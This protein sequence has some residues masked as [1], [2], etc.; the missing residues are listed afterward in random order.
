MT[1]GTASPVHEADLHAYVD[2]R[3]SAE[4]RVRVEAHLVTHPEDAA[5]V[6]AWQR[7]TEDLRGHFA[8]SLDE[9]V[10]AAMAAVFARPQPGAAFLRGAMRVAAVLL[11][12]AVGAGAGWWGRGYLMP[13]QLAIVAALPQEAARAHLVYSS[14]V[15]HPVEVPAKEEKHLVAWLSKRLGKPLQ[16]PSLTGQGYALV[17]GRLLPAASDNTA[18]AQFMYENS[19]G[20]RLTLYVRAGEPAGDTSFRFASEGRAAAF[21]WVDDGFG[22]ALTGEAGRAALLPLA[23]VVYEQLTR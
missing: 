12:A 9:S 15:L 20:Q 13:Q 11:V 23:R 17:G 14:E 19:A 16:V 5:R 21:Y 18:A 7:Q 2:D 3:L 4:E 6:A 22:Y 1:G 8:G 10:P